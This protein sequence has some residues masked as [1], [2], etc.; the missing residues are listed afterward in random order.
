MGR[1]RPQPPGSRSMHSRPVS[2]VPAGSMCCRVATFSS[3][4]P[5]PCPETACGISL[6]TPWSQ[7]CN[8]PLLRRIAAGDPVNERPDWPNIIEEVE[9]VGRSDLRA[10]ESL[11]LQA[12][13]HILKAEAWPTTSFVSGWRAEARLFRAQARRAF[14]PSMRQ[15][16]DVPGL[17]TDALRALP[18]TMDVRAPG[19]VSATCH[20]PAD[21]GRAAGRRLSVRQRGP[22][23]RNAA[24]PFILNQHQRGSCQQTALWHRPEYD[25]AVQ[26]ACA[27]KARAC[28]PPLQTPGA[29]AAR[30]APAVHDR[31]SATLD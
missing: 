21:A 29:A 16:L 31:P 10:V 7:R 15:R 8:A 30:T 12:L 17:Y 3:P 28:R 11:L 23:S 4:S 2:S 6:T 25:R 20:L 18:E 26:P 27:H 5:R 19:P 22:E 14:A 24:F 1:H 13:V 9:S